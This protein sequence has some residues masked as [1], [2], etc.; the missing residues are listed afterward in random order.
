MIDFNYFQ[1]SEAFLYPILN[2]NKNA[3]PPIST[4]LGI[5]NFKFTETLPLIILYDS[6]NEKFPEILNLL[7]EHDQYEFDF[8]LKDGTHIVIFD[9]C[10]IETDYN[11]FIDGTY[12]RLSTNFKTVIRSKNVT[13]KLILMALDPELNYKT[14]AAELEVS[15][16]S[17]KGTELIP[18]P[19]LS[20]DG[21]IIYVKDL[22]ALKTFYKNE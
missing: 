15:V 16:D 19:R 9:M 10:Y 21:E 22:S 8:D 20:T 13:N 1:K 12:S 11:M 18:S 6:T 17:I 5:E 4:H 3:I 7:K 2:I 14:V